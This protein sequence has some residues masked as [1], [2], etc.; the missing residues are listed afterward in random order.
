MGSY[1]NFEIN[2][3]NRKAKCNSTMWKKKELFGNT[4]LVEMAER[5]SPEMVDYLLKNDREANK[6]NKRDY[7][8]D[9]ALIW[10]AI[11]GNLQTVELL[12]KNN[13]NIF[14]ENNNGMSALDYCCFF[15]HLEVAK[16]I[17]EKLKSYEGENSLKSLVYACDYS[18]FVK[19][20]EFSTHKQT[21]YDINYN[22]KKEIID[23]LLN[24]NQ[25][26]INQTTLDGNTALIMASKQKNKELVETLLMKGADKNIKNNDE[27]YAYNYFDSKN[28]K[29]TI[30]KWNKIKNF[31]SRLFKKK[32]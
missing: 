32:R 19:E 24:L 17:L 3:K 4:Y 12:L 21:E 30:S 28:L 7:F 18:Y 31:F 15:G 6:V 8:N 29:P 14:L 25:I 9:T 13:A 20:K 27:Q 11:N 26:N 5:N 22:N 23:L 1:W 16:L 10:G 2:N